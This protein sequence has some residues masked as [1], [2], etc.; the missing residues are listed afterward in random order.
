MLE[1]IGVLL[2]NHH[3]S[4]FVSIS[5]FTDTAAQLYFNTHEP[6]LGR[7]VILILV[8]NHQLVSLKLL[9]K[10]D[11]ENGYNIS[12]CV[13]NVKLFTIGTIFVHAAVAVAQLFNHCASY[14][15]YEYVIVVGSACAD[16]VYVLAVC[17]QI[18]VVHVLSEY[19]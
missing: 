10:L 11:H 18:A 16:A 12:S 13:C 5:W 14:H 15:L 8:I 19:H 7:D 3:S 9:M 2:P 6:A 17:H 1:Y 4:I